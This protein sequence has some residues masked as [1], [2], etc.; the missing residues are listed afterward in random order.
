MVRFLGGYGYYNLAASNSGDD[1]VAVICPTAASLMS[2]D[3][4]EVSPAS[5]SDL[6]LSATVNARCCRWTP[7]WCAVRYDKVIGF[8]IKC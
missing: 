3:K 7:E 5:V 4:L 8:R 1:G 6:L 2:T